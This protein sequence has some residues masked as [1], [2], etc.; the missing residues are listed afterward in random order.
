M[1]DSPLADHLLGF[2][3]EHHFE[4]VTELPWGKRLFQNSDRSYFVKA[5]SDPKGMSLIRA[6]AKGVDWVRS[7]LEDDFSIPEVVV[8]LDE[9]DGVA[10]RLSRVDGAP[11]RSWNAPQLDLTA[12]LI[13]A[14]RRVELSELLRS[15]RVAE[16]LTAKLLKRFGDRPVQVTPSH[17]DMIYWNLLVGGDKLGLIDFEYAASQRVIGFDDLHYRLAPWMLRW[18]R[19]RLPARP[20]IAW[21]TRQAQRICRRHRLDLDPRL[22]LAL[23]FLHWSAI[24]H[25]W[26]ADYEPSRIQRADDFA[27]RC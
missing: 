14:Q 23:F 15:E 18:M 22:M 2:L 4:P 19:W 9:P 8:L 10:M 7:L 17:G 26:H 16:G 11:I 21:G 12:A 5:S 25:H 27:L 1:P 13:R 3:Q 24:Q 20:L 6:E